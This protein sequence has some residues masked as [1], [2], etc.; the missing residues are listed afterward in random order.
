[1]IYGKIPKLTPTYKFVED[2]LSSESKFLQN[3]NFRKWGDY[4]AILDLAKKVP[5]G[6][7][8]LGAHDPE[9][10]TEAVTM[11]NSKQ[12][13]IIVIGV[14]GA[15]KTSLV[16][17]I[18]YQKFFIYHYHS[19]ISDPKREYHITNQA[20]D[21][22]YYIDLLERYGISVNGL[23]IETFSPYFVGSH[24]AK[25]K[26]GI[27]LRDFARIENL[28]ERKYYLLQFLGVDPAKNTPAKR[29]LE[30][31]LKDLYTIGTFKNLLK[32][33]EKPR[34]LYKGTGGQ[35]VW[36]KDTPTLY[37]IIQ[38]KMDS[39]EIGNGESV[40]FPEVMARGNIPVVQLSIMGSSDFTT[41]MSLK[42]AI[43]D[44]IAE[45]EK[46]KYGSGGI[47]PRP[48]NF[49]LE[50]ADRF[51]PKRGNPP[52]KQIIE[53][54]PNKFR[55]LDISYLAVTQFPSLCSEELFRSADYIFTP[56]L[57]DTGD[58]AALTAKGIDPFD[59]KEIMGKAHFQKGVYPN[60]WF[61]ID[62]QKDWTSFYPLRSPL[63]IL[64]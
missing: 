7:I 5:K 44:V 41:S 58:I 48:V 11:P 61:M 18:F 17:L 54:I 6:Q 2:Y 52:S 25:H 14:K 1:M 31:Y 53:L 29:Q 51:S 9:F 8:M 45:R 33:L 46:T 28:G 55:I 4:D 12:D 36:G 47:L 63:K 15:G 21:D 20:I 37:Q 50:E 40:Y 57:K 42:M 34:K 43:R 24:N 49:L 59:A 23:P 56:Q 35:D 27:E 10:T 62:P 39:G 60:E 30:R 26:Y 13:N 16:E 22:P 19:F 64:A 32:E 38:S 3:R